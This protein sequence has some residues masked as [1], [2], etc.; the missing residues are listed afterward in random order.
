MKRWRVAVTYHRPGSKTKN[1]ERTV[2]DPVQIGEMLTNGLN[3]SDVAYLCITK[4][5]PLRKPAS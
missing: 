2:T 5:L 1:E 3:N 4:L